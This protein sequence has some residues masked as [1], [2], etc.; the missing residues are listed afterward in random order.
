MAKGWVGGVAGSKID[1]LDINKK[2]KGKKN[3]AY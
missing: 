3:V 1:S 2:Q